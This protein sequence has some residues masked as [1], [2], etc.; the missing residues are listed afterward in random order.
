MLGRLGITL[1]SRLRGN[2]T[3]SMV[4][5]SRLRGSDRGK[6]GVT[7]GTGGDGNKKTPGLCRAGVFVF[8]AKSLITTL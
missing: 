1:D 2:D 7:R 3:V 6:R 8:E 4:L 5:G